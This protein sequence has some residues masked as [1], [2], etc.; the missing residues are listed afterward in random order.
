MVKMKL[1]LL[2]ASYNTFIHETVLRVCWLFF[3][4]VSPDIKKKN[5]QHWKYQEYIAQNPKW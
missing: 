2:D 5:F 3:F 4:N 1:G